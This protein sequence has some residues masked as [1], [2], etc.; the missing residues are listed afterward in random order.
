MCS[1]KTRPPTLHSPQLVTLLIYCWRNT[2]AC[3][4]RKAYLQLDSRTSLQCN[5]LMRVVTRSR[6][7]CTP[8][9]SLLWSQLFAC[10][11]FAFAR[12]A[13]RHGA[14]GSGCRPGVQRDTLRLPGGDRAGADPSGRVA[15]RLGGAQRVPGNTRQTRRSPPSPIEVDE[16][17]RVPGEAARAWPS[18]PTAADGELAVSLTATSPMP[19]FMAPPRKAPPVFASNNPE[20]TM[21]SKVKPPLR[22]DEGK[23]PAKAKAPPPVLPA[24]NNARRSVNGRLGYMDA[25]QAQ[26]DPTSRSSRRTEPLGLTRRLVLWSKRASLLA[27]RPAR[28]RP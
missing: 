10:P 15:R 3:Y 19:A 5:A 13:V 24:K 20:S 27:R 11:S 4:P 21:P 22:A 25:I 9:C 26:A 2:Y 8:P 23:A 7:A 17:S 6:A 14:E 28:P 12:R 1:L 18:N 16:N